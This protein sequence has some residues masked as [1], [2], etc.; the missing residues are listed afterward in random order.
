MADADER[1]RVLDMLA[2]GRISAGDAAELLKALGEATTR[3]PAPPT[4]ARKGTARTFRVTVDAFDKHGGDKKAKVRV[5]IPIGLARFA[6][7]FLPPEAKAELDA[8][9]ID[10][11]ALIDALGDDVPDGPL[12]DI[13]VDDG[14]SGAK[15]AKIIIEVA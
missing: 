15:R 10:L 14:E 7:R 9:G 3:G 2:E 12:V 5:N 8:Q 4:P 11:A 1:R 6:S 13:D